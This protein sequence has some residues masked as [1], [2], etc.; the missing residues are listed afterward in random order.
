M[1]G[2]T[3]RHSQRDI[4]NEERDRPVTDNNQPAVFENED[5]AIDIGNPKAQPM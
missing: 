3:D 1:Q 5:H 2:E 4:E